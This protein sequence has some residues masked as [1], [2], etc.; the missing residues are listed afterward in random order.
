MLLWLSACRLQH[1]NLVYLAS[2]LYG[3]FG[4]VILIGLVPV[5]PAIN[6]ISSHKLWKVHIL[7]IKIPGNIYQ[8]DMVI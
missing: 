1:E 5:S 6:S 8:T 3:E 7:V 2:N 4:L